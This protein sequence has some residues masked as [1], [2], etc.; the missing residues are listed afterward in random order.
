MPQHKLV[1][2][3]GR[4]G[5]G[6]VW[7]AKGPGGME[8]ALKIVRNLEGTQGNQEYRSLKLIRE[9]DHE[10]LIRLRAFWLLTKDGTHIPDEELE[11]PD[12]REPHAL[13]M[14]TDLADKSLLQ[15]W[16]EHQAQGR[17]SIPVAD[18]IR[19]IR[20]SADAIDY[21]NDRDILHR[22]IKPE[23]IL[24]TKD[25]KV[26][27]SDFGLAKFLE[28]GTG[29]AIHQASVGT[30][31]RLRGAQSCSTI[32]CRA[33]PINTRLALDVLPIADRQFPVSQ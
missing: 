1:R 3:L 18:L 28:E 25:L 20:Q 16:Q 23:N 30:D 10:R 9:L 14:A 4:G 11:Q 13:V 32:A 6:E 26:K 15:Y 21:V 24:L 19:I 33:G 27:V 2:L 17:A 12:S 22:D 7:A 5:Y 29:A 31:A 8:C